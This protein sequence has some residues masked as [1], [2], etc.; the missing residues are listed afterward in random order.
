MEAKSPKTFC[1]VPGDRLAAVPHLHC[2]M[3]IV[4]VASVPSGWSHVSCG[5]IT[6]RD[7]K[8]SVVVLGSG[9]SAKHRDW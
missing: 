5:E 7:G 8:S 4:R 1:Q 6:M 9:D 3:G 2:F